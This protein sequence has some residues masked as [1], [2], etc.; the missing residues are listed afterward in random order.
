[1]MK[2]KLHINNK[3]FRNIKIQKI[4]IFNYKMIIIDL[5]LLF[6]NINMKIQN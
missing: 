2:Y 3:I 5:I 4:K 6:K 1:M